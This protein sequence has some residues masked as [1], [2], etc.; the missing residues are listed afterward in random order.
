MKVVDDLPGIYWVRSLGEPR[1][2]P[3]AVSSGAPE[4]ASEIFVAVRAAEPSEVAVRVHAQP[5]TDR[6]RTQ[7]ERELATLAALADDPFVIDLYEVGVTAA[8]RP[9]LV[10]EFCS[11]GSLADH[12][13]HRGRWSTA[14]VRMVGIK[15]AG[16]LA[17]AQA[18]HVLH[19]NVKPT[20][21]LINDYGEPVLSDFALRVVA[22]GTSPT[23]AAARPY[24][25]PEAFL[26]ELMTPAAD[27][28]SVG[29]V[30]YALLTGGPPAPAHPD[31]V[32]AGEELPNLAGVPWA[33]MAVLRR[34]MA[35]DPINRYRN[36][37]ELYAALYDS[38]E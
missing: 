35:L 18:Q 13:V 32:V 31:G 1:D 26:P 30:L 28:F 2:G 10:M 3:G 22:A 16:A 17:R 5:G 19:G 24:A 34:A 21:I 8:G 6:R 11:A 23:S 7:F 27:V 25:A 9:Y 29:A 20:N 15:I 14:D 4:S 37:E 12:M 38:P 36:A 33:F